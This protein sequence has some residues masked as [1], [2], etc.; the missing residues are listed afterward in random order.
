M[1]APSLRHLCTVTAI[2]NVKCKPGLRDTLL[3]VLTSFWLILD[4][5]DIG[6][7]PY[8]LARPFLLKIE[9][10]EKLVSCRRRPSIQYPKWSLTREFRGP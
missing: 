10:P 3:P 6:N 8:E 5:N 1:P 2:R 9:S 7:I 4:L